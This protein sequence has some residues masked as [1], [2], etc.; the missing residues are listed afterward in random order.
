MTDFLKILGGTGV[1]LFGMVL[2]VGGIA[3]MGDGQSLVASLVMLA[4]L[5]LAP[6]V[7]GAW[8]VHRG[9]VGLG[10]RK[11]EARERRILDLARRREGTLTASEVARS[12]DL[13]LS[14]ARHLLDELHISGFCQTVLDDAG[15]LSYRFGEFVSSKAAPRAESVR[16][17]TS[18]EIE[19]GPA[20][21][22]ENWDDAEAGSSESSRTRE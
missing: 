12:T 10:R 22:G 15:V 8:M 4:A 6:M 11:R 14:E 7:A 3:T 2:T 19:A 9:R 5:G 13:T 18:A 17:R 1:G 21:I 20:V 16:Q